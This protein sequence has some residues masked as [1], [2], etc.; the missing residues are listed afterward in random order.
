MDGSLSDI[1]R[2]MAAKFIVHVRTAYFTVPPY[3]LTHSKSHVI[4][5]VILTPVRAQFVGD[6]HQPLHD[7]GLD[8]GGNGIK[9]E[10]DGKKTN[11][12]SVWDTS[13]PERIVGGYSLEDARGWATTISRA[14]RR[15][16]YK[17][18]AAGWVT[19]MNVVDPISTAM[20]WATD[21]NQFVCSTVMPNGPDALEG[22]DLGGDYYDAAAP[23][24]QLQ[25]A[26]AGYRH[27]SPVAASFW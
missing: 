17:S 18:Q 23:V 24:V 14:I 27:V 20:I 26:K 5:L 16:E 15:G 2:V 9:V 21:T 19:D 11:L 4:C 6:I 1:E 3:L 13:I 8:R 22:Q 12:H 7:E 10:F 25:I